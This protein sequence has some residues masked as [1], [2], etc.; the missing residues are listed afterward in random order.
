M[1]NIVETVSCLTCILYDHMITLGDEVGFPPDIY[2]AFPLI[3]VID[4]DDVVVSWYSYC[5]WGMSGLRIFQVQVQLGKSLVLSQSLLGGRAATVR[6]PF[7]WVYF[8]ALRWHATLGSTVYVCTFST[9]LVII[10]DLASCHKSESWGACQ[11]IFVHNFV[12]IGQS[13]L[14]LFVNIVTWALRLTICRF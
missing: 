7:R 13:F 12:Y 2:T 5:R 4:Q 9:L 3:S 10:H 14:Q 11:S 8:C 1:L 6:V